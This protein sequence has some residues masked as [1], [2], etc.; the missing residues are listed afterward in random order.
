MGND[1]RQLGPVRLELFPQLKSQITFSD[2]CVPKGTIDFKVSD[3]FLK[4]HILLFS[5][6][7]NKFFLEAKIQN[8][9]V[10][11][12]RNGLYQHS[13]QYLGDGPCDVAL[14]WDIESIG[15]GIVSPNSLGN[16]N[17]HL[18]AIHTPITI[19]PTEIINV[20]RKENLLN[21]SRYSDMDAF[22]ASVIDSLH[23]C[24]EDIKRYGGEKLLWNKSKDGKSI[25]IDE[26][27][28]SRYVAS[29]LSIYGILKNFDVSC[30]SVAGGGNIDFHI[31]APVADFIGKIAVEAKKAYSGNLISAFTIQL[32]EYM[33]SIGTVYGIYLVYW[34][35]SRNYPFPAKY[36]TYGELEIEKL[37]P[38]PRLSTMR[39]IGMDLSISEPPSKK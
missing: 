19:P 30:E 29:F 22:F 8:G 24:Q 38:I 10:F 5:F 26:P 2:F 34:L 7:Y 16:M 27:E 25:P 18:R 35:K 23:C 33:K 36:K 1:I 12:N 14:Q 20:L 13:E 28:I 15:C 6:T 21:N 11:I 39:T 32:P 31:T 9:M 37:H 3:G 4:N 17:H